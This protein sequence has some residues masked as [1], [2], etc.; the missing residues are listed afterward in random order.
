[1]LDS[2]LAHPPGSRTVLAR[3]LAA[4]PAAGL[5]VLVSDNAHRSNFAPFATTQRKL[6]L[7]LVHAHS[8]QIER[9]HAALAEAVT[10]WHVKEEF[11]DGN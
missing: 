6:A 11:S 9:D 1:M 7:D 5:V 8:D 2:P 3:N 10:G 4:I